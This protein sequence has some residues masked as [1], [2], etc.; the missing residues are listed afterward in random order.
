MIGLAP[1]YG[2]YLGGKLGSEELLYIPAFIGGVIVTPIMHWSHGN[3]RRG[4]A[5]FGLNI[6]TQMIGAAA[7]GAEGAMVGLGIWNVLDLAFL[8]HA[9]DPAPTTT[10]KFPSSFAVVPDF[11]PEYKGLSVVGQF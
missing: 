3:K 11:R 4:W 2:L 1:V 7:N 5:S 9:D 8:H 10:A 6:G